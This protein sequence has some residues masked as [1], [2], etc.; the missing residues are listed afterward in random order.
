MLIYTQMLKMM[1]ILGRFCELKGYK[2]S[3][4]VGCNSIDAKANAVG[5]FNR[6]N[7]D[8]FVFL[9]T[10]RANRQDI[11]MQTIDRVVIFDT[12]FEANNDRSAISKVVS[13]NTSP[14]D[15][16]RLIVKSSVEEHLMKIVKPR[17]AFESQ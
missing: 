14:V 3:S 1:M 2:Y 7:S 8:S 11:N 10:E 15:V 5:C 16:Y 4:L 6:S 9:L 13:N 12:D 17:I